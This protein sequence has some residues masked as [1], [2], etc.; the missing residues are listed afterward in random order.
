VG[1]KVLMRSFRSRQAVIS[2]RFSRLH[3]TFCVG[4]VTSPSV[5]QRSSLS[6]R[7]SGQSCR[8]RTRSLRAAPRWPTITTACNMKHPWWVTRATKRLMDGKVNVVVQRANLQVLTA[9]PTP[10]YH[11]TG[12]WLR[13]RIANFPDD[14][15]HTDSACLGCRR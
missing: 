8:M 10:G 4:R 6:Q 14:N 5:N 11:V 13:T 1:D 12:A 15:P 3:V 2:V 9:K 7:D